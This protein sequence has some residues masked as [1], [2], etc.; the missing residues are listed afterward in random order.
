MFLANSSQS[1]IQEGYFAIFNGILKL[2]FYSV[3]PQVFY[4]TNTQEVLLIKTVSLKCLKYSAV[5]ENQ[6]IS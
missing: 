1:C 5:L 6:T 2:R 3:V 4:V